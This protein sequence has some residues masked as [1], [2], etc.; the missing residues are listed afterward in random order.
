MQTLNLLEQQFSSF[1]AF[2][3]FES[4]HI[5]NNKRGIALLEQLQTTLELD[6][7]LN[8]FAMEASKYVNFCG[9][10]FK[11]EEATVVMRGHRE[12]NFSRHFKLAVEGAAL[13][14]LTY[15]INAK[16]AGSHS[17]ILEELHTYLLYP[18]KNALQ[19]KRALAMAMQDS[20][21][22]LGNRRYYDEQVKR[23]MHQAKRQK[24]Q[25]GLIVADLNK[26]K[27]I[28]DTYGHAVGDKVLVNF[29]NAL[30]DSVRDSD[31][32]F[33]FGG[34]EFVVLIEA[35]G[36]E[37]LEVLYHR[38]HKAVASNDYLNKYQV[39][40]SL[41]A[42]FMNNADSEHSFFERADQALYRRKMNMPC[43]LAIV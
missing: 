15:N 18:L 8:K 29:A 37:A 32:L 11:N 2:R 36:K 22:G 3:L 31:S 30:R 16:F 43:N 35:A 38:I 33:R 17:K 13:G 14:T 20:L 41:G 39:T 6:A 28:N 24:S 5:E 1:N 21:T 10:T 42:T 4:E 27:A 7:L 23:A 26:F 12:G 25:V 9:L 40:C 19:F 34:D